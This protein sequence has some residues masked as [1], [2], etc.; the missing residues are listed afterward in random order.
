MHRPDFGPKRFTPAPLYF[1][2]RLTSLH[3]S[4]AIRL[5]IPRFSNPQSFN[6]RFRAYK[7]A[8]RAMPIAA[9]PPKLAAICAA[10]PVY[11]TVVAVV[12][13]VAFLDTLEEI[14]VMTAEVEE[15]TAI[16]LV[17]VTALVVGA[18]EVDGAAEVVTGTAEVVEA[19]TDDEATVLVAA[20][21]AAAQSAEAAARTARASVAPQE[22]RTQGVAAV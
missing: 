1:I 7:P 8:I 22:L 20:A 17:V 14:E 5:S 9:M 10:A 4:I 16:A 2:T 15:L 21:R 12:V 6:P 18:A 19:T 3:L 13:A 11:A